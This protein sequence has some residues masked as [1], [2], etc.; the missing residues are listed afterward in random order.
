MGKS[1]LSRSHSNYLAQINIRM[2]ER[3]EQTAD[4]LG[5]LTVL[6]TIVLPMNII[7]GLWG[8][9]CLVPG[10][11]SHGLNWFFGSECLLY[12]FWCWAAGTLLRLSCSAFCFPSIFFAIVLHPV[13]DC[14][15]SNHYHRW[16]PPLSPLS[17]FSALPSSL[18]IPSTPLPSST[19]HPPSPSPLDR[20]HGISTVP[21]SKEYHTD[22]N[23]SPV[24]GSLLIFGILCYFIA[25]RVYGIV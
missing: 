19:S 17:C 14:S 9:N 4:V 18:S 23:G 13:L 8:M 25:K 7:T 21:T 20:P 24:S 11:D 1:I 5:R 12:D 2:N 22:A 10:Q 3:Q 15:A 16:D 6:G